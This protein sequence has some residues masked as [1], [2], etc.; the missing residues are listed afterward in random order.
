MHAIR[1]PEL[2]FGRSG[3]LWRF[4]NEGRCIGSPYKTKAEL[5][6]DLTRYAADSWGL[7]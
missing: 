7:E 5:L 2:Q 6:A 4:F 3:G 1:F